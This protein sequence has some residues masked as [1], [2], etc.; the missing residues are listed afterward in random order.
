MR[1]IGVLVDLM[2]D[3]NFS[4]QKPPPPINKQELKHHATH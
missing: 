3:I 4:P 1:V 2:V